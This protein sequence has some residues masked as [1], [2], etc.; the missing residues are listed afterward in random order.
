MGP[1]CTQ[2]AASKA[3][4]DRI[5]LSEHCEPGSHQGA[6]RCYPSSVGVWPFGVVCGEKSQ[7]PAVP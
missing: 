3:D 4:S 5:V 2:L 6:V 7:L 1:C